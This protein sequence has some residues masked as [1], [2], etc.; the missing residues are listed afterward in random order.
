[1]DFHGHIG[2]W[3][4]GITDASNHGLTIAVNLIDGGTGLGVDNYGKSQRTRMASTP[5]N[6]AE[7]IEKQQPMPDELE[8]NGQRYKKARLND[9]AVCSLDPQC[10]R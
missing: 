3:P 5:A 6:S 7:K 1:M 10:Q 8:I 9:S 4:I 2:I